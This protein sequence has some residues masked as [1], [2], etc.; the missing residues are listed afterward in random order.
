[1][2]GVLF[3]ALD[4]LLLARHNEWWDQA[5]GEGEKVVFI[6]LIFGLILI[7]L[8]GLRLLWNNG[9]SLLIIIRALS[10]SI[11]F[12]ANFFMNFEALVER[13]STDFAHV[14]LVLANVSR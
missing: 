13:V 2:D 4:D 9:S 11:F 5:G 14:Y 8:A 7:I 3:V 10:G 1:M 12:L 6:N